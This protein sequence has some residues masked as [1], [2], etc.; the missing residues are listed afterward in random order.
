MD[1]NRQ[2]TQITGFF[3][4]HLCALYIL[5]KLLAVWYNGNSAQDARP[6]AAIIAHLFDFVNRQMLQKIR[7]IFVQSAE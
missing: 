4:P 1:C 3:H 6:R 2:N 7:L 5:T